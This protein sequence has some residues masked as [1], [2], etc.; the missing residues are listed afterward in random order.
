V[1]VLDTNVIIRLITRDNDDHAQRAHSLFE[2]IEGGAQEIY[3][4]EGVLVEIVQVLESR[5][6]YNLPP[7]EIRDKVGPILRMPA[8]ELDNKRTC[9]RALDLYA[10]L[11]RLSFV[12]AL[13]V[14]HAQRIEDRT[15]ISFDRDFRK[16]SEVEW[17]QP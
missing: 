3:M 7:G 12:D 9:L 10:D 14:A 4:P 8:I 6:L 11:G 15:V 1:A 5:D 2:R 16:L 17:V 13:C